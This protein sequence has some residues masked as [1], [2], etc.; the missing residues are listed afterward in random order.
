ME[1][2]TNMIMEIDPTTTINDI[3]DDIIKII[4]RM[5]IVSLNFRSYF[6]INKRFEHILNCMSKKYKL[7]DIMYCIICYQRQNVLGQPKIYETQIL[8]DNVCNTCFLHAT[9]ANCVHCNIE[10]IKDLYNPNICINCHENNKFFVLYKAS[11]YPHVYRGSFK[12][13][14]CDCELIGA[15]FCDNDKT[16]CKECFDKIEPSKLIVSPEGF[17]Y[18]INSYC[19]KKLKL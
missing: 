1:I 15:E 10:F 18:V 6:C 8:F 17:P 12:C 7:N 3:P 5:A 14:Y 9:K 2:D 13:K 11:D 16:V 19:P 4:W